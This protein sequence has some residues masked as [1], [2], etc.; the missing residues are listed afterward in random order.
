M[1]ETTD[2]LPFVFTEPFRLEQWQSRGASLRWTEVQGTFRIFAVKVLTCPRIENTGDSSK[3]L[4]VALRNQKVFLESICSVLMGTFDASVELRI[5]NDPQGKTISIYVLFR[6]FS[7]DNALNQIIPDAGGLE[8][9]ILQVLPAE[10]QYEPVAEDELRRIKL[11]PDNYYV[12]SIR[13]TIAWVPVGDALASFNKPY[14]PGLLPSTSLLNE[15]GNSTPF[16]APCTGY[17]RWHGGNWL[18]LWRFLQGCLD[19]VIIRIAVGKLVPHAKEQA[20]ANQLT[21]MLLR[22]YGSFLRENHNSYLSSLARFLRPSTLNSFE[23]QV[24]AENPATSQNIANS[25][26]GEISDGGDQQME[27]LEIPSRH[28]RKVQRNWEFARIDFSIAPPVSDEI[29]CDEDAK[30]FITR[31]SQCVDVL[32]ASTIF[33]LPIA[34][35]QGLPGIANRPIKPFYQPSTN[36]RKSTAN[37]SL[38]Y[39]QLGRIVVNHTLQGYHSTPLNDLTRHSLIV[40]STGSGKSN[41]TLKL[42]NQLEGRVSCLIVEPV[43]GEYSKVFGAK[44]SWQR[45]QLGQPFHKD[46]KR[47]EDFLRFNPMYVPSGI[48]VAQHISFIKTCIGAAFPMY[49]AMPIVL[50]L[51]LRR[52]YQD[53]GFQLFSSGGVA[54]T[55][56]PKLSQVREAVFKYAETVKHSETRAVLEDQF[57]RRFDNLLGGP[58]GECFETSDGETLKSMTRLF[59]LSN[60]KNENC[61]LDLEALADDAEKSLTMAFVFTL[62]YEHRLSKG[63]KPLNH[64]TILEEAHRLLSAQGRGGK[65]GGKDANQSEDSSTRAINLF[66]DMLAEI[67]AYGEGLVV[68]EQI[69]SKLVSEVVKNTNLKIMHRITSLDDREYLGESMN[70]DE[71]QKKYVTNLKRGEAVLYE[72]S[73][74]YP[75]LVEIDKV[76]R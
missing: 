13:K 54:N 40:G 35:E 33:R 62:L 7:P 42:I 58:L 63:E 69:P 38:D 18:G 52:T 20:Y 41:T 26:C 6:V 59:G 14:V 19:P 1:Y 53:A 12:R 30:T 2:T 50:E 47:R 21:Y 72:E 44:E 45:Y 4:N 65:G 36:V 9:S 32:E 43:K 57:G 27:V 48:T 10:F 37:E 17:V 34:D 67:R 24:A 61:V 8:T 74:D 46:G 23:L 28:Y 29:T 11:L 31:V 66:V 15:V 39:L 76:K 70:F 64:V 75:V 60:K 22:T 51:A 49:G 3:Y 73:L 68:V 25:I 5:L 16:V 55:G 71:L 56:W